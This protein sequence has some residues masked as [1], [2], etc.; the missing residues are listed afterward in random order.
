[1]GAAMNAALSLHFLTYHARIGAGQSMTLYYGAFYTGAML[2]VLIW[3][4]VV[5]QAEKHHVYAATTMITAVVMSSGYWLIGEGRPFGTGN[6]SALV[7]LNGIAGFFGIAGSVIAPSMMAD[8][9][10]HDERQGARR[11]DGIFFGV[12][13]F[14]QQIAGG[15]A[16]LVAGLLVD[17]FAGL[18]PAQSDQS[19]QTIE[20]LVIVS[21]LLPAAM[22]AGAALV[23]LGYPLTRRELQHTAD[24]TVPS[25][26]HSELQTYGS[27]EPA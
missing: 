7:A 19:S 6:I 9:T 26:R 24:A 5:R 14:G 15:L 11:R 25:A 13:S 17:R 22:L 16:V 3:A 4:R 21:N 27:S 20:R 2:G 12:Y 23:A 18:V 1:M 10:A 8:I